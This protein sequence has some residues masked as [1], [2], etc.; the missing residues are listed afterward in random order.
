MTECKICHG[1]LEEGNPTNICYS[2]QA[3]MSNM[4][5]GG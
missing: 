4:N 3:I 2:C 1:E 5:M